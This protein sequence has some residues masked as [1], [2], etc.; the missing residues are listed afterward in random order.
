MSYDLIRVRNLGSDDLVLRGNTKYTIP[1]NTDRIIPFVEAAAWFGDP[2]LANEGRE[3]LREMAYRQLQNLW[4]YT[5]GMKYLRDRWDITKGFL[6]WDDFKPAVQCFDMD[7]NEVL[8]ILHDPDGE[9]GGLVGT[10]IIDP[11]SM[12]AGALQQQVA[13]L[14]AS[15][16]QLQAILAERAPYEAQIAS[17][18]ENYG[19]ESRPLPPVYEAADL[20][21]AQ[22]ATLADK[23]GIGVD[24]A[25]PTI[26]AP[27]PAIDAAVT[28]PKAPAN[29]TVSD[30]APRTVRTGGRNK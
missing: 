22:M 14:T 15:V 23:F 1:P 18:S 8:F 3:R 30:D 5:E 7:G 21:N 11:S 17:P 25:D 20:A 16:Q 27:T 4:G 2:R 28:L 24:P 10:G 13:A 9:L 19:P 6:G 26:P 29:D 12:D